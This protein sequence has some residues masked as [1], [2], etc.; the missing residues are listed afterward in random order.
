[1][2]GRS[3]VNVKVMTSL[4]LYVYARPSYIGASLF[5]R[6]RCM[7]IKFTRQWKP[8]LD[9]SLMTWPSHII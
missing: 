8:P 6:V 5:T 1:M 7:H 3:R 9:S 2:Y 4:N